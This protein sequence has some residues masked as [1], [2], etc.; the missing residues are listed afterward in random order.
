MRRPYINR[1]HDPNNAV[2]E[3]GHQV[4]GVFV[5]IAVPAA[6]AE[7]VAQRIDAPGSGGFERTHNGAQR[8]RC[9]PTWGR[10]FRWG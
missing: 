5:I 8:A 10:V 6:H 3:V 1:F 4:D 9:G 2:D 7:G